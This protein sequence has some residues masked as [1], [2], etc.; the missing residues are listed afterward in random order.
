[1]KH[2]P[3]RNDL[4]SCGS[5]RKFKNCCAGK[6][7]LTG[8]RFLGAPLWVVLAIAGVTVAALA[9][10]LAGRRTNAP[11]TAVA[12]QERAAPWAYD[13]L[14][15]RHFDPGHGHWHD[16]PPP[17]ASARASTPGAPGP[18]AAQPPS[19]TTPQDPSATAPST[20]V[21][22]PWTYDSE[23]NQHWDPNHQH[24][25]PGLPPAGK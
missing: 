13:S 19:A 22:D 6:G 18:T 24:W 4:C 23:K 14:T 25:H 15:N 21:P 16:G 5:G 11:S 20:S 1:M 12:L 10:M 3:S 17:A 9:A 2:R 8:R 7:A